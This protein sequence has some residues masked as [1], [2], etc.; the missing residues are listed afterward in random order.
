MLV[1]VHCLQKCQIAL[2]PIK[3]VLLKSLL[4]SSVSAPH[5]FTLTLYMSPFTSW[6]QSVVLHFCGMIWQILAWFLW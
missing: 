1:T 5:V 4:C 6:C 2:E 3:V